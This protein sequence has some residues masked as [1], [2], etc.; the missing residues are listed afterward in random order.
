MLTIHLVVLLIRA[1]DAVQAT[2]E[3]D[4]LTNSTGTTHHL[5]ISGDEPS[6]VNT[7]G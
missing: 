6:Y 3:A 4:N 5:L 7:L 2:L 1:G